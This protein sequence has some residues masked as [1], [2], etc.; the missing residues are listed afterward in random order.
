VIALT[1]ITRIEGGI[2]F[3]LALK[4]DG[5][6]W[7][8]G[9]NSE[10]ELGNGNNT[11]SNVPVQ[12][13]ALTS[14][15]AI[16]AGGHSLALKNDGTVWTWGFNGYGELGN[17]T[18]ADSNVPV[19]VTS[20]CSILLAVETPTNNE[21]E[22]SVYPN[23]TSG[24]FTMQVGDVELGTGKC[25]IYNMIGKKIYSE[26]ITHGAKEINLSTERKGIYFIFINLSNRII[27]KKIVVQ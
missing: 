23:P 3:S 22:I 19:Q 12:V 11:G 7:A 18:N 9:F 26:Q 24:I 5:T 2:A 6:V 10:G 20:L 21:T 8:W 4:N 14:V 27:A 1:G 25:E 15:I 17:G 16:A 13:S